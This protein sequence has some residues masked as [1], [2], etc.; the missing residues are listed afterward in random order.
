MHNPAHQRNEILNRLELAVTYRKDSMS[1]QLVPESG[2]SV[3]YAIPGARDSNGV[4]GVPGGMVISDGK[5]TARHP[6]AFGADEPCA[7]IILTAMKSDPCI[8]SA[9][10]IRF[11]EN[12]L[13]VFEAMLLECIPLDHT[14]KAPGISSMDWGIAS[15]CNDGVPEIIYDTGGKNKPGIIHIFGEDPVVVANNIIICSNRI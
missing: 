3:G 14:R 4:A 10:T 15:S 7:R 8:R 12:V 2:V 9:A 13:A 5:V 1:I 11:S 6:C